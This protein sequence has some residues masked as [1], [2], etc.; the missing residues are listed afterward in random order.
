MKSFLPLATLAVS[1]TLAACVDETAP[2]GPP[3]SMAQHQQIGL[4]NGPLITFDEMLSRVAA[5]EPA[6]AGV[7]Q[8]YILVTDL[9]RMESAKVAVKS[10]FGRSLGNQEQ[11]EA[12]YSWAQ[13]SKWAAN[14]ASINSLPGVTYTDINE[15]EN[16]L[17]VGVETLAQFYAVRTTLENGGVPNDAIYL[18]V[19]PMD[20]SMFTLQNRSRG[21]AGGLRIQNA[22]T[23]GCTMGFNAVWYTGSDSVISFATNS[24]C[25]SVRDGVDGTVHYQVDRSASGDRLGSEYRDAPSF[26]VAHGCNPKAG[27]TRCKYSDISLA[28]YDNSVDNL[29]F[30]LAQPATRGQ[31]SSTITFDTYMQVVSETLWPLMGDTVDKIGS[32]TGWTSGPVIETCVDV[33]A[34]QSGVWAYTYVCQY[35]TAAQ[36]DGGDSGAGV[37][38]YDSGTG[39]TL[40]G[41]MHAG[42]VNQYFTWSSWNN[43]QFDVGNLRVAYNVP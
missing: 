6:F 20:Q 8:K 38:Y 41:Q 14:F 1:L 23:L 18:R 24:H 19:A 39:A 3:P 25:T 29:G 16:H 5:I 22:T 27:T 31:W 28:A 26:D 4:G 42:I 37:F 13:L 17:T 33:A 10:V 15:A 40:V 36:A 11:K 7:T 12:K 9:S 21:A 32:E 43:I 30:F 35:R 2:A 34:G